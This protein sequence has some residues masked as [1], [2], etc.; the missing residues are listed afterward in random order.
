MRDETILVVDLEATCWEDQ[1]TPAGDA[2]SVNNMEIIGLTRCA[3]LWEDTCIREV[4]S[5]HGSRT[6]NIKAGGGGLAA[7]ALTLIYVC[8]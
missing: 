5:W 6:L 4:R 1:T 3:K 7:G 2:Q 8:W